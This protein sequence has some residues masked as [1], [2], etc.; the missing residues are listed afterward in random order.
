M[1]RRSLKSPSSIVG[2]LLLLTLASLWGF[3]AWKAREEK[4]QAFARA[5]AETHA[6]THSLT[7]HASKSFGAVALALLGAKQYVQ[8]SD[9]SARASAEINDLLA[10]YAQSVPHVNEFGVLSETGGW[11]YSSFETIPTVNNAD[12]GY[13]RH[14]RDNPDEGIRISDPLISRVSGQP[15]VVMT[16]RIT[17]TDGSFAGVVLG[18]IDLRYL[19]SFYATFEG[20]SKRSITLIKTNGKVLAHRLD[21][22]VGMDVSTS[23]GFASRLQSANTTL[24]PI[25]SPFDGV[26]KQYAVNRVPDFPLAVAV[27]IPEA[28][29]LR[30]WHADFKLDMLLTGAMSLMLGTLGTVLWLQLR[31]RA[32]MTRLLGEKERGYRLLAENAVD[33]VT[34]IAATGEQLYISPSVEKLTGFKPNE[35]I[36][37]SAYSYIHPDHHDLVKGFVK[38]LNESHRS[39][40]CEYMIRHRD[41][42]YIWVETQLN[43]VVDT[44]GTSPEIVGI[45]R[46]I[47]RRKAAEERLV[48]ANAQLKSLSETDMLTGVANRRK[49]DEMFEKERRRAQGNGAYL[50]VL[51][52]DID[53]FKVFNDTYGHAAGDEC[54][55][56]IAQ[57][58]SG[59]LK[60]PGDLVG[61]YG[62]E[63]F[64]VIL[65]DTAAENAAGVAEMLRQAVSDLKLKHSGGPAGIVTISVGVAGAKLD[66]RSDGSLLLMAADEQLYRAKEGGRNR[67]CLAPD[68][69]VSRLSVVS[70]LAG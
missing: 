38:S 58:M 65:P 21:S 42:H 4:A 47:S 12:R 1:I 26:K 43:F 34:R 69:E 17:N 5:G 62:G 66:G 49:F 36:T 30:G 3:V 20:A 28:E 37:Q 41:G 46:D 18:A 40:T 55:R 7:Q 44:A 51:F 14:H 8:H 63:E 70:R 61:R 24:Y 23:P 11:L 27:A 48:A 67:V 15:I 22:E 35:I 9:R 13:F 68:S 56:T 10:Q 59:T 45:V 25:V 2:L 39:I 33:V 64:A 60:R 50:S 54:I 16:R 29:I 53:K 57:T 52:V 19:N 32:Q 6:L 31:K